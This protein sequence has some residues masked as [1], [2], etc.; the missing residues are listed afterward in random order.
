VDS[1]DEMDTSSLE[2]A[3]RPAGASHIAA[4]ATA[5]DAA[6]ARIEPTARRRTRRLTVAA[7]ADGWAMGAA[8]RSDI[9]TGV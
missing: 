7:E 6:S 8:A 9:G 3:H 4:A 2:A 1:P 5:K